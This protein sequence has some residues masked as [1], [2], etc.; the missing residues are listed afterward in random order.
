M[1]DGES[2]G[3]QMSDQVSVSVSS[4]LGLF[5]VVKD[6]LTSNYICENA[7]A[8]LHVVKPQLQYA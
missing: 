5:L 7:S 6:L 2:S 8:G 1:D 3:S 4:T